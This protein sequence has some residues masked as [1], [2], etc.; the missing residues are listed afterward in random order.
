MTGYQQNRNFN[1]PPG[2]VHQFPGCNYPYR[3]GPDD[4]M[5]V[6]ISD[7][8]WAFSGSQQWN[9]PHINHAATQFVFNITALDC[10]EHRAIIDIE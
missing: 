7:M 6:S 10:T 4:M 5:S 8:A 1:L 9:Q 3:L 2:Y